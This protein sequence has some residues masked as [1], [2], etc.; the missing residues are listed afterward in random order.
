MKIPMKTA[1]LIYKQF[2]IR[3]S[4]LNTYTKHCDF[5]FKINLFVT[6]NNVNINL[7]FIVYLVIYVY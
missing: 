3:I 1:N 2:D 6:N 4:V 5:V 7:E